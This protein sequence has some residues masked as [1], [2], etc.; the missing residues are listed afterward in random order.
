VA[1]AIVQLQSVQLSQPGPIGGG[2]SR[3]RFF[4]DYGAG[5]FGS[6]PEMESWFNQKLD[7]CKRYHQARQDIPQFHF[8]S[9]V[10]THQDISPRNLIL[11]GECRIW[12]LDW[13][14]AGAYPPGFERAALS[15]Q[16]DFPD[17][18]ALVL[19]F[20]G[21]D[22]VETLQLESITYGLTTGALG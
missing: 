14:D 22:P 15:S 6:G 10:L 20:L 2:P 18:G 1:A 9:F 16:G 17:F 12:V 5:P 21:G 11:D 13:A 8:S 19:S 7:L 3:G 4:T